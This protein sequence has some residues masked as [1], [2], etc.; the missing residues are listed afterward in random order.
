MGNM[1]A[2]RVWA[3]RII[4]EDLAGVLVTFENILERRMKY[5]NNED[6]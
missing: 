6:E 4:R 1:P 2:E 3:Q 5:R